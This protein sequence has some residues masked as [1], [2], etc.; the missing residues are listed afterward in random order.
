LIELTTVEKVVDCHLCGGR[1]KFIVGSDD[2]PPAEFCTECLRRIPPALQKALYD[3]FDYACGVNWG[4]RVFVIRF[5]DATI[6]GEW[7][8]LDHTDSASLLDLQPDDDSP[9][10]PYAFPRGLDVRLSDIVWVA[11]APQGS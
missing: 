8:T 7:V 4:G 5:E 10:L 6:R 11:D 1:F 9:R 2:F 3:H